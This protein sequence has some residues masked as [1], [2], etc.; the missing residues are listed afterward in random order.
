MS[1]LAEG[2]NI[3]KIEREQVELLE[4]NACAFWL[5]VLLGKDGWLWSQKDKCTVL[6]SA[7]KAKETKTKLKQPEMLVKGRK[8]PNS[9]LQA[10]PEHVLLLSNFGNPQWTEASVPAATIVCWCVSF[11]VLCSEV[12]IRGP[13]LQ[14]VPVWVT[15]ASL[16]SETVHSSPATAI[17]KVFLLRSLPCFKRYSSLWNHKSQWVG[18]RGNCLVSNLAEVHR[19][20]VFSSGTRATCRRA[21]H[22]EFFLFH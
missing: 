5:D 21:G 2:Q 17:D 7:T 3:F 15:L 12:D 14:R 19:A 13:R 9:D 10:R 11:K 6:S 22:S 4:Q 8:E 1:L 16:S 20:E 18:L